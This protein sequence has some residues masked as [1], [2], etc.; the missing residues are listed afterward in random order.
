MS[1]F[2]GGSGAADYDLGVIEHAHGGWEGELEIVSPM[3]GGTVRARV[4][5]PT[6]SHGPQQP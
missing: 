3:H 6:A 2:G 1:R 4:V 5:R